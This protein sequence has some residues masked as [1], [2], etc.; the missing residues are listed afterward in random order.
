MFADGYAAQFSASTDTISP[1]C[2]AEHGWP[3]RGK[4]R[5]LSER[6]LRVGRAPRRPAA[7]REVAGAGSPAPATKQ[8]GRFFAPFL[9][10]SKKGRRP[11]G[12]SGI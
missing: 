3:A 10:A 11:P 2:A 1:F 5:P 9:C 6:F 8:W 7:R 4:A 12:E